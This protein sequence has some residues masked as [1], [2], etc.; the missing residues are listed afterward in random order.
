[1]S[2]SFNN[3][4][5]ENF[6]L[7]THENEGRSN[8]WPSNLRTLFVVS[9]EK[10]TNSSP[11]DFTSPSFTA[12]TLS[13]P[14]DISKCDHGSALPDFLALTCHLPNPAKSNH[15]RS[16]LEFTHKSTGK[17][18]DQAINHRLGARKMECKCR[19]M[20]NDYCSL[21]SIRCFCFRR[22]TMLRSPNAILY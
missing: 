5:L 7:E 1:M 10:E 12:F 20:S 13:E 14:Q 19:F 3:R 4:T 17:S 8:R 11:W 2:L 22:S 15:E 16:P 21:P 9:V 6:H 18:S